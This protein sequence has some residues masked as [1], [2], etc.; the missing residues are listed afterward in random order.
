ME[1]FTSNMEQQLTDNEIDISTKQQKYQ[2]FIHYNSKSL[3]G[4]HFQN[5][6]V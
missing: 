5:A 6:W 2:T 4:V 3:K 1:Y